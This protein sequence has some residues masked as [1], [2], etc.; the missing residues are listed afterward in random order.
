MRK[1]ISRNF[2]RNLAIITYVNNYITVNFDQSVS[3]GFKR[4]IER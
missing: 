4:C 2:W 1:R 3:H